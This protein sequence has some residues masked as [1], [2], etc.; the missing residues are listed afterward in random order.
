MCSFTLLLEGVEEL[1]VKFLT[2]LDRFIFGR[3]I[4]YLVL[5]LGTFIADNRNGVHR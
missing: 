1:G 2:S 5:L 4:F 3:K